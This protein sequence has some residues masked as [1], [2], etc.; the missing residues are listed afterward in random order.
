M[1]LIA[2]A[3]IA[4]YLAAAWQLGLRLVGATQHSDAASPVALFA[5]GLVALGL[6]ALMLYHTTLD[7]A[8]LRLGFFNTLSLVGW[9]VAAL[10][11]FALRGRPLDNLGLFVLPLTATTVLLAWAFPAPPAVQASVGIG[12]QVHIAVSV[13][14]YGLL[15][16]AALQATLV[17]LQDRLLREK[18]WIG[19]LYALPPLTRQES[20]LFQLIAA[21]FFFLSLSLASG[22]MYVQNLFDQHL[23]HKTVLTVLA[24]CVFAGLLYGRWRHGWRG[25]PVVRWCLIAF[26]MLA[27]G[28]FGA[29]LVLEEI[30]GRSWSG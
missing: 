29:K 16:L 14:G 7:P 26:V 11:L 12:L 23:V 21:G 28:Y 20:L 18:R 10:L 30:L 2:L 3:C 19:A 13:L 17:E 1:T 27:L 6:H 24:W 5:L 9:V 25:S 22:A 8:G 15:A 4:L